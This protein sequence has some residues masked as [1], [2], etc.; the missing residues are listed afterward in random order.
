MVLKTDRPK[1]RM[2]T[3]NTE[4][5]FFRKNFDKQKD[6]INVEYKTTFLGPTILQTS[7]H[8]KNTHIIH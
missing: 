2:S 1:T 4:R 6:F 7:D 5:T 3:H 8:M